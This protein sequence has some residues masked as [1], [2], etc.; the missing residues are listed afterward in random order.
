MM[1]FHVYICSLSYTSLIDYLV[2][3]NSLLFIR[4]GGDSRV[5]G[6]MLA[7]ATAALWMVG[8]WIVGYIPGNVNSC[9]YINH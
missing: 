9:I 6:I 3:T 7:G 8:P 1:S 4:T 2:Y 5:A